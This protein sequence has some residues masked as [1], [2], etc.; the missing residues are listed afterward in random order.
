V[1][2]S[3]PDRA[4]PSPTDRIGRAGSPLPARRATIPDGAQRSARLTR[5]WL[6]THYDQLWSQAIGRIRAGKVELDQLLQ[7]GLPD[8]RRG[9]TVVAWPPLAVRKNVAGFLQTLHELEPN[10]YYYQASE[11][12]LTILSLFTASVDFKPL[13]AKKGEYIAAVDAALQEVEPIQITFEGVTVSKN[14]IMIQ[15]FFETDDLNQLRDGLR[16]QLQ[17]RSL[18]KGV[19]QRY[20]LQTAHMTVVRFRAPLRESERFALA[21]EKARHRP[22]G[23]ATLKSFVLVENDWYMS[24]QTTQIMERYALGSGRR[25]Y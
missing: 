22:F 9:L 2:G 12:H 4:Y 11:L 6:R 24:R 1:R 14:T 5:E 3:G 19:D 20:R 8:S 10:Q 7:E 25:T 23:I 15:G 16:R 18:A 13:L 17:V 21:L